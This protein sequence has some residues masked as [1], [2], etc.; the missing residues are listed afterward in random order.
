LPERPHLDHLRR[1]ARELLRAWR[2]GQPDA[3]AR[4]AP[5]ALNAAASQLSLAQ[6][7]IARE[8]G[9]PSWAQLVHEVER[10]Q[11]AALSDAA[12]TE[13]VLALAWG[14]GWDA[15]Q[16]ERALALLNSRPQA[17]GLLLAL[18]QGDLPAVQ[19]ALAGRDLQSPLPPWQTP[20]L[21]AVAFSSLARLDSHRPGLLATLQ[22]LLDQG[23]DPNSALVDPD[24]HADTHPLPALYGATARAACLPMVQ[25]LLQ[26]GAQPNDGESL[27]HAT[28]QADLGFVA[29]LVAAGAR[30]PGT[31]ALL[32]LLDQAP[33]PA[34]HQALALGADPNE[35]GPG[36]QA[37]LHH[38]LLRGRP[39]VFVQALLDHGADPRQTDDV[40][41]DA[42]WFAR[43]AGDVATLAVLQARGAAG[44]VDAH[45]A[46]LAACAAGDEASARAHLAQHPQAL[47]QCSEEDLR[48]LP[49]QAQRGH[50]ASV[51]L[52]L[53]L[54]W[55]VAVRGDWDA[56]ALN[57]AAFRGD[58]ALVALL[59]AHGARWDEPNGFGGDALGSCLHAACNGLAPDGDHAAVLAQ[60]LAQGAPAPADDDDLPPALQAVLAEAMAPSRSA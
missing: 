38:A 24:P 40:G 51:R 33:L 57:Q 41:H 5:C 26:A 30:W 32:R 37:A 34:L 4:A 46:F 54:G 14:R 21:A 58:A 2:A 59:I 11:A 28:E 6:L 18:V 31:N 22:W 27:Y 50:A 29:A 13:R 56:S 35:R 10:R 8:L 48:L 45:Q 17:G 52:M 55:P 25:A 47:A 23:A 3:L 43:R 16:P 49:D 42:A 19:Q 44:P 53:A 60:L 39:A 36:G 12:F 1:Q 7:V 15:P 9:W 20:P